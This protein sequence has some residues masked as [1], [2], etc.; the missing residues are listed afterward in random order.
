MP[1]MNDSGH[2]SDFSIDNSNVHNQMVTQMTIHRQMRLQQEEQ[3][4]KSLPDTR[5]ERDGIGG[6]KG[7]RVGS[8]DLGDDELF[9]LLFS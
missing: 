4:D 9:D 3:R 7:K 8:L 2:I 5:E 1:T 6:G